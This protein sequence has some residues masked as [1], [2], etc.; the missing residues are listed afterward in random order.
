MLLERLQHIAQF[1]VD[2]PASKATPLSPT[3]LSE[4]I[5]LI[6]E[7]VNFQLNAALLRWSPEGLTAEALMD[8]YKRI[9]NSG[10]AETPQ[11]F[12]LLQTGATLLLAQ[13]IKNKEPVVRRVLREL[14]S[15]STLFNGLFN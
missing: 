1:S 4:L 8:T 11:I 5:V 15:R 13:N 14:H 7:L 9:L 2:P 10:F 6:L 12:A 3:H